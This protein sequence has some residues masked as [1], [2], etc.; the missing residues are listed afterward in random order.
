[1]RSDLPKRFVLGSTSFVVFLAFWV[2]IATT[3]APAPFLL[4]SP[5]LVLERAASFGGHWW[6]HI[7]ATAVESLGGFVL[8]GF[9]GLAAAIPL[10]LSKNLDDTMSPL[11]TALQIAPKVAL[12]PIFILWF[13]IGL[14]AKVLIAFWV[15]FFPVM[16]ATR[17]GFASIQAEYLDLA[18]TLGMTKSELLTHILVP[19]SL[20]YIFSGL[21]VASA[22]AL[23]GA[24][25]GEFVSSD[26]GLGYVI[27]T[28]QNQLDTALAIGAVIILT[29]MG[30]GLYGAVAAVEVLAMPWRQ[31][32][33]D[34]RPTGLW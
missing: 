25:I 20:P 30:L 7:F 28:A 22:L 26:R 4:P 18:K 34:T 19:S 9:F 15:A 17:S 14:S 6:P 12:A 10:V 29:L 2:G 5:G 16:V 1:M 21:R 33:E 11:V 3:V 27:V 13:G 23:V 32:G 24:V 8:A 31:R